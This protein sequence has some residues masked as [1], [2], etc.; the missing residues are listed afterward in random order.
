[1]IADAMRT[2]AQFIFVNEVL[3]PGDAKAWV[4]AVT[5]G[6][7]GATNLH[8]GS[9]EELIDRLE[10][11]GVKRADYLVR[12]FIIAVRMENK[13]VVEVHVPRRADFTRPLPELFL[14]Y[15]GELAINPDDYSLITR[16]WADTRC[17]VETGSIEC[18][19]QCQVI[20]AG[21]PRYGGPN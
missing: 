18:L 4:R 16:M 6:H 9:L 12:E 11:L 8:A 1:M 10:R 17:V 20:N 7:G 15:L 3:N 19:A 14:N 2:G 13:R 21:G 5:S